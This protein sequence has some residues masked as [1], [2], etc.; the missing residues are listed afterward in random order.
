MCSYK[1]CKIRSPTR[2]HVGHLLLL[3]YINDLTETLTSNIHLYADDCVI[4][5]QLKNNNDPFRLQTD[6]D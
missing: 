3:A 5:R 2:V 4:Y 1:S 6:L